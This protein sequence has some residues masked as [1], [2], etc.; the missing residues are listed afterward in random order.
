[1]TRINVVPMDELC[2]QHLLAEH[3]ELTRIPN[4]VVN[5]KY[6][7]PTEYPK[8]YILGP[9]HVKFFI[10]KMLFLKNR[11]E[12]FCDEC[13]NRGFKVKN[14]WPEQMNRVNFPALWNDYTI[15]AGDL[16]QN[17]LRIQERMPATPRY[18]TKFIICA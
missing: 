17:R 1:M 4:C 2:D 12:L 5:G 10:N 6:H 16:Y 18:S 9:G 3:R 14:I 8:Y 15:C 11:Y 13:I 7:I